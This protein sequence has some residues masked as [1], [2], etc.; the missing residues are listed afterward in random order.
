MNVFPPPDI[1]AHDSI[2][3]PVVYILAPGRLGVSGYPL[4]P[5]DA[6][7]ICVNYAVSIPSV[8]KHIWLAEDK[9]LQE[10]TELHPWFKGA[11]KKYIDMNAPL[12]EPSP[13]PIFDS[14][15]L[16]QLYRNVPYIYHSGTSMGHRPK[17]QMDRGRLRGGCTISCKAVQLAVQKGARTVVLVGVDM[18]GNQY[19]DNR[20]TQSGHNPDKGAWWCV[21][22]FNKFIVNLRKQGVDIW[23]LTPTRLDVEVRAPLQE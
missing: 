18:M 10:F 1:L 2:F 23:S 15:V 22:K 8:H 7:V 19:W 6:F 4:I 9:G 5:I 14:G 21:N 16:F 12:F 17:Y 13:T 11:A 20:E 3:P